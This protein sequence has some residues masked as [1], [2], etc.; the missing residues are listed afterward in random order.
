MQMS[1]KIALYAHMGSFVQILITSCMSTQSFNPNIGSE[2]AK[3]NVYTVLK[4]NFETLKIWPL[5]CSCL[6]PT[7]HSLEHILW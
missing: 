1:P 5:T 7:I 3:D 6:V 2:N 4:W